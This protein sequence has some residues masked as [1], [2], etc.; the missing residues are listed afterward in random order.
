[1]TR[2]TIRDATFAL[3]VALFAGWFLLLRPST[4]GGPAGY[5]WV[6]GTSMEP[7]LESGDLVIVHRADT[8]AVGDVV[9]Y[10]VPDGEPAAGGL[11]IHRI[12]G[13]SATSGFVTQGD[14]KP[15]PDDWHPKPNDIVGTSWFVLPGAGPLVTWLRQ[16]TVV[17]ALAA[18]LVVFSIMMSRPNSYAQRR[19]NPLFLIR[20]RR[21]LD[22]PVAGVAPASAGYGG[23]PVGRASALA[24][25]R[26]TIER[27]LAVCG[28][29]SRPWTRPDIQPPSEPPRRFDVELPAL[30]DELAAE[31]RDVSISGAK[32]VVGTEIPVSTETTLAILVDDSPITLTVVVRSVHRDPQGGLVHGLE[33]LTGQREARVRLAWQL[34][35]SQRPPEPTDD[36]HV[37]RRRIARIGL[38]VP[39]RRTQTAPEE[40]TPVASPAPADSGS[41][42]TPTT[43]PAWAES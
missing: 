33:F 26:W 38:A 5:L 21:D 16:P 4:L 32:V 23:D 6:N 35:R 29:E 9:G 31:T 12:V 2:P 7:T 10:R 13:G 39:R 41:A 28:P 40:L 30:L 17:G 1:M 3:G 25:Y 24:P 8:Y 18:A 15:R 19:W 42:D 43:R 22:L 36:V 20:R 11:V 37:S 34:L 14:N 27:G